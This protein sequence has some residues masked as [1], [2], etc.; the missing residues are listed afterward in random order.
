MGSKF[1]F[2]AMCG[3]SV[4]LWLS[5]SGFYPAGGMPVDTSGSAC[6][7]QCDSKG[8]VRSASPFVR[9]ST[10][11]VEVGMGRCLTLQAMAD[12]ELSAGMS[13]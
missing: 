8:E 12:S 13:C 4:T 6:A 10:G 1:T 11:S 3:T 5:D 9:N 7:Q 2:D